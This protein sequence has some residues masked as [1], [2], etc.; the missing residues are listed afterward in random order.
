MGHCEDDKYVCYFI[1]PEIMLEVI[2]AT[3][4]APSEFVV[5]NYDWKNQN[6]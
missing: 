1:E 4:A 3:N 2:K 6:S 5:H